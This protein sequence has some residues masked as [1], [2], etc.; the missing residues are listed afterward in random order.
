MHNKDKLSL[1]SS[2][3]LVLSYWVGV[4]SYLMDFYFI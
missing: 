1:V 4:D 3:L 2:D